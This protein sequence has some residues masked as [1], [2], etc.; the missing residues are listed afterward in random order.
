VDPTRGMGAPDHGVPCVRSSRGDAPPPLDREP[1]LG[2]ASFTRWGRAGRARQTPRPV[3][4]RWSSGRPRRYA[5]PMP[6]L[7]RFAGVPSALAFRAMAVA[8]SL[9]AVSLDAR[10]ECTKDIECKGNRIRSDGACVDPPRPEGNDAHPASPAPSPTRS[11][12]AAPDAVPG[13]PR[14]RPMMNTGIGLTVAGAGAFVAAVAFT[15]DTVV[16]VAK[17]NASVAQKCSE[18]GACNT[19]VSRP[20]GVSAAALV[21]WLAVPALL[22]PGIPLWVVGGRR[23]PTPSASA[24]LPWLALDGITFDGRQVVVGLRF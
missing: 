24:R 20:T 10:A 16:Q 3:Q 6:C 1:H 14:N 19:V 15:I 11:G 22:G 13:E 23:V 5:G 9:T 17:Y 2:V 21:S 12:E 4:A 7:P 18:Q 8:V